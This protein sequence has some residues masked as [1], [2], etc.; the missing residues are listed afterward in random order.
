MDA[1]PLYQH[2]PTLKNRQ[3]E[4]TVCNRQTRA[5]C[6]SPYIY[7]VVCDVTATVSDETRGERNRTGTY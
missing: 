2:S 5:V 3:P 4:D 7:H 6:C 1:L